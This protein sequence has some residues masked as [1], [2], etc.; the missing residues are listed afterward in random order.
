M[1]PTGHTILLTAH[2]WIPYSLQLWIL[3][4]HLQQWW[5]CPQYK[6]E[7]RILLR[8]LPQSLWHRFLLH[9]LPPHSHLMANEDSTSPA[10][11]NQ[12]FHTSPLLQS[13]MYSLWNLQ[14]MEKLNTQ[15]NWL[16]KKKNPAETSTSIS[17]R[18]NEDP[19]QHP[20]LEADLKEKDWPEP[21]SPG[22]INHCM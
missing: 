10:W 20:L 11:P 3:S 8:R 15:G 4:W 22:I 13:T 1:L 17:T 21:L 19:K 5:P 9:R 18:I 6:I 2:Y 16:E 14:S 12:P 7:C